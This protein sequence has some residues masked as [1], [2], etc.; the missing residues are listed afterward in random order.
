LDNRQL[1][2][3]RNAMAA[4]RLNLSGGMLRWRAAGHAVES[5]R[6]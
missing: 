2:T 3:T 6:V 5:G 1:S 4:R